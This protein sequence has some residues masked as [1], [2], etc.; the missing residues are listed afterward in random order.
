MQMADDTMRLIRIRSR[1]QA[2]F[3]R[4]GVHRK[5]RLADVW[6]RPRGLQSKQRKQYRA[7]G[8]H[9]KPG[10]GAPSA[11]RGFHPSGVEEILVY[12]ISDCEGLNP[13][14]TAIRIGRTVG[15]R[16][17]AAIQAKA[18]EQGLKILNPKEIES[19]E[20]EVFEDE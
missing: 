1:K 3:K 12:N 2:K 13:E 19:P 17:R 5:K 15:N 4:Q 20:V 14:T 11:I 7:K 8:R 18:L 9:P 6:R 10:F 16:K